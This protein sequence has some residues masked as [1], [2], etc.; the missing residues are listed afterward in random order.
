[1]QSQGRVLVGTSNKNLKMLEVQRQRWK[2]DDGRIKGVSWGH[3][4]AGKYLIQGLSWWSTGYNSALS[5]HWV[6]VLFLVRELRIYMLLG[7]A[8]IKKQQKKKKKKK[9]II[10]WIKDQKEEINSSYFET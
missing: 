4:P 7:A 5:L 2:G 3:I 8:K 10:I 1:M 6:Q 9:D